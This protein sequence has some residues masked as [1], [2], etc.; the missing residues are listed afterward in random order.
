MTDPEHPGATRNTDRMAGAALVAAAASTVFAMAHHP[1]SA[2]AGAMAG[3]VHGTMIVLL[4]CMTF[5]FS[6]F[7][8]RRG[9]DRPAILA[10]L[11]A[12]GVGVIAN[13][14]AAMLNGF[15]VPALAARDSVS[16]DV[17]LF[18][19]ETNQALA[20]LGIYASGAAFVLWSFD[21]IGRRRTEA[22]AI[23]AAGV[24]AGLVP[25][26]LLAGGWVTMSV[27]GAFALYGAHA[28]WAALV[29]L[30]VFRGGLDD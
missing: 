11:I 9:L 14:G 2:H 23:G 3:I 5:G 4:L 15:V 21:F 1:T 22:R 13:I 25:A 24:L 28:A 20:A 8:R 10:G 29:G 26:S 6:Y 16:R 12:Y 7:V 30:H 19:W 18:A 27:T 17:F